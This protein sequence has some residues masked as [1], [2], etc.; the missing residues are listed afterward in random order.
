MPNRFAA[1]L[2]PRNRMAKILTRDGPSSTDAWRRPLAELSLMPARDQGCDAPHIRYAVSGAD[3]RLRW[4]F[5]NG[6]AGRSK[7]VRERLDNRFL[8]FVGQSNQWAA[9]AGRYH[10]RANTDDML[11]NLCRTPFYS[12]DKEYY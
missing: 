12:D 11:R 10:A 7:K 1:V 5:K 4:R 8:P 9:D 2:G 6:L 3:A